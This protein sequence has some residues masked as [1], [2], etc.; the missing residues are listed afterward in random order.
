MV[1][2]VVVAI[3]NAHTVIQIVC[4]VGLLSSSVALS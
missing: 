1:S 4:R 2:I 3:A